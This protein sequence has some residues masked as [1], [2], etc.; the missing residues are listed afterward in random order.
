M[1]LL[2]RVRKRDELSL[3]IFQILPYINVLMNVCFIYILLNHHSDFPHMLKVRILI[4]A[5]VL[6]TQDQTM[7]EAGGTKWKSIESILPFKTYNC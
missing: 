5:H 4:T 1:G 7:A 2:E 3:V 6:H